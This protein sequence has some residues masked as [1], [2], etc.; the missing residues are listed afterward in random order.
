[1]KKL[2]AIALCAVFAIHAAEA[3]TLYVNAKA[4][5]DTRNG[6]SAKKAKKTIQAAV[7]IA[8][9]GDT[10]LVYPGAYAPFQTQNKKITIKSVKGSKKT[11][12]ARLDSTPLNLAKTVKKHDS[13]FNYDY[14]DYV[15]NATVLKGFLVD[16]VSKP[17]DKYGSV[18]TIYNGTLKSCTFKRIGTSVNNSKLEDCL[19]TGNYTIP[20]GGFGLDNC[21]ATRCRIQKSETVMVWGGKLLN[22]SITGNSSVLIA[23]TLA[24]CL[25]AKNKDCS[26]IYESTLVNCTVANNIFT[27][28]EYSKNVSSKSKYYNCI[29][30]NNFSRERKW[31]PVERDVTESGYYDEYG[32][33]WEGDPNG[34]GYYDDGGNFVPYVYTTRTD[35]VID[36]KESL[37]PKKLHNV[38]AGNTYKNTDKTNKNPKLTSAY[39]PKKGSYVIDKGKLTKAQKKLVGKKDLAGKNRINGKA[40]DRGC[41]EY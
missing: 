2:L 29:L 9:K 22:C 19:F 25:V 13:Q 21:Q 39:K 20:S 38:D 12:I 3:R 27:T 18:L 40:I 33:W 28:S 7:N 34:D 8:K 5:N 11:M 35:Q 36:Y 4:K 6:L 31:V 15:G 41:Y 26:E 10:I 23:A 14:Y 17:E 1:M 30:W 32:D 37:G 24:N 16:G